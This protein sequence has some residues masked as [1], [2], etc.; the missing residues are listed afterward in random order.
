MDDNGGADLGDE[1]VKDGRGGDVP[2]MVVYVGENV[3]SGVT[4]QDGDGGEVG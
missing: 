4:A 3:E 2:D 1:G